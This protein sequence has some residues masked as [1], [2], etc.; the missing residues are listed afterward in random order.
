MHTLIIFCLYFFIFQILYENT[1]PNSDR[2]LKRVPRSDTEEEEEEEDEDSDYQNLPSDEDE[3]E[4]SNRGLLLLHSLGLNYWNNLNLNLNLNFNLRNTSLWKIYE[5]GVENLSKTTGFMINR[6]RPECLDLLEEFS[7]NL[8]LQDIFISSKKGIK[9]PEERFGPYL[10]KSHHPVDSCGDR[11]AQ[12][13]VLGQDDSEEEGEAESEDEAVVLSEE[14]WS[15]I[16]TATT[17]GCP[18]TSV[19]LPV[20]GSQTVVKA[21]I[22]PFFHRTTFT[23]YDIIKVNLLESRP[24]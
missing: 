13:S 10:H 22:N 12:D 23:V 4:N 2:P 5:N 17:E 3:L 19:C 1:I 7:D 6:G 21:P 18:E 8:D 16:I 24:L 15:S 14:F 9:D 20:P 11:V